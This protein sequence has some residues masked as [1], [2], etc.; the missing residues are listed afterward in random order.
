M[1][2][3]RRSI[4]VSLATVQV[5]VTGPDKTME[6]MA[7]KRIAHKNDKSPALINPTGGSIAA[8][9]ADNFVPILSGNIYKIKMPEEEVKYFID[10]LEIQ[11]RLTVIG[12][13]AGAADHLELLPMF[14]DFDPMGQI[15]PVA[16]DQPE[17]FGQG[18]Q[19]YPRAES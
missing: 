4:D 16:Q 11:W 17:G 13:L 10:M 3:I 5:Q 14:D 12:A 8:I 18:P 7:D 1:L 2:V 15:A 6:A 9:R 19:Q